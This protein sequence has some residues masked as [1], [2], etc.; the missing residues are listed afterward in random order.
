MYFENEMDLETHYTTLSL[1]SGFIQDAV[2]LFKRIL[3]D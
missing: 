1:E 2:I 3:D